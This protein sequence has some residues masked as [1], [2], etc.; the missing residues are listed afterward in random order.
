MTDLS[1][2]KD[3]SNIRD[4]S[5]LVIQLKLNNK[6]LFLKKYAIYTR[7]EM[8]T[9]LTTTH[10]VQAWRYRI[11]KDNNGNDLS[12]YYKYPVSLIDDMYH[13]KKI[14]KDSV[15]QVVKVRLK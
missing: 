6:V 10:L 2:I 12:G 11:E 13:I 9:I 14:F 7:D 8:P 5:F 3:R 1:G 15:V 4:K